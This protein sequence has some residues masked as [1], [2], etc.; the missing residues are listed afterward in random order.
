MVLPAT[1]LHGALWQRFVQ[2]QLWERHVFESEEKWLWF[3]KLCLSAQAEGAGRGR[4]AL[5]GA[6]DKVA[7]PPCCCT[8]RERG[9]DIGVL[10]GL[11][12]TVAEVVL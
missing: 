6:M 12:L 1:A 9:Q 2:N 5:R 10:T 7:L 11:A 8:P 3:A 4:A